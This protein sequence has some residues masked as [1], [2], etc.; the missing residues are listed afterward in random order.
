MKSKGFSEKW[1][2]GRLD[3]WKSMT[4][5]FSYFLVSHTHVYE[6][7]LLVLSQDYE[8]C[9]CIYF[10]RGHSDNVPSLFF[11]SFLETDNICQIFMQQNLKKVF[12]G[13]ITRLW[14]GFVSEFSC[15]VFHSMQRSGF[16][17]L[18]SYCP[19]CFIS[20]LPCW[21]HCLSKVF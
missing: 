3:L 4:C 20:A 18:L 7:Y 19:M 9:P 15:Y 1:E 10:W 13:C 2:K 8:E 16:A 21:F 14:K 11:L 5:S 17:Y 12:V 6:K